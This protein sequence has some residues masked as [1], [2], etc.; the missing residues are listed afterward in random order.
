MAADIVFA[1]LDPD[2]QT[3]AVN[4]G[5]GAGAVAVVGLVVYAS[6]QLRRH[7]RETRSRAGADGRIADPIS[8][9]RWQRILEALRG[10]DQ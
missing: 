4:L 7:R 3:A 10:R 1:V 8:E 2:A 5:L 6:V 9:A